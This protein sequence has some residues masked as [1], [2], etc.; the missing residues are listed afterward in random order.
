MKYTPDEK[1]REIIRIM[2]TEKSNWEEGLVWATDNTQFVMRNIVKKARK[3]YYGIYTEPK[4]PV[5]GRDKIFIP[6]TEWVVE[7]ML[8]N[9]DI[10]TNDVEVKAK[11]RDGYLKAIIW[12]YILKK[13]L[14]DIEFGK[15]LNDLLRRTAV[16]GTGFLK[17]EEE[18]GKLKVYVVDRLNMYYDPAAETLKQSSGKMER[19]VVD[20][21]EFDQLELEN[22]EY[23]K[24]ENN[25]EQFDNDTKG[26]DKEI[27]S[28]EIFQ[29]FGWFPKFCLTGKEE[30]RDEYIYGKA[31]VS[32][33]DSTPV[34]HSFEEVDSDDY[35]EFRLKRAPNRFDGRGIAEMLFNI[36]AY[37]NE[38]INFRLNKGRIVHLGLFKMKGSITPQQFKRLFTTGGIKLGVNDDI[39]PLQTG[40]IDPSSYKDEEQAYNW[41]NRVC[42]TTHEDEVTKNRPATNALIEQQGTSKGYNLRIEDLAMDLCS[43][44]KDKMLPIINKELKKESKKDGSYIMRITGDPK[45]MQKIDRKLVENAIYKQVEAMGA[46][47]KLQL[48]DEILEQM[49]QQGVAQLS[50]MGEDRFIPIIDELLDTDFDISITIG[51]EQIN[52][53]ALAGMLKE[54]LGM[55]AGAGMPIRNT[56]KELYDAMGL[57]GEALIEEM[58]EQA[59]QQLEIPVGQEPQTVPGQI[60]E[61]V[62][63]QQ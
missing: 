58:P 19:I 15:T 37:L 1:E 29:R 7:T 17:A 9:I 43:F 41:G 14:E 18:D 6:F 31:V 3:N 53:A 40:A 33:L 23:V 24:G 26:T 32:G 38:V 59:P 48:N 56:L 55:L 52:K 35:Q 45:I 50:E 30:D 46:Y 27:P 54:T 21:P 34:V 11:T 42:G 4:D 57:D 61:S 39:E 13:K 51:D 12:R 44:I 60:Q 2:Q 63:A 22:S 16:D 47:E 25:V 10:D 5:T 49:I 28:V 36:Q 20:K 62:A 8:K